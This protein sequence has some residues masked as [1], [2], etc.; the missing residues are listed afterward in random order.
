VPSPPMKGTQ[1]YDLPQGVPEPTGNGQ[2]SCGARFSTSQSRTRRPSD[3]GVRSRGPR[4]QPGRIPK[5]LSEAR[6]SGTPPDARRSKRAD[7][8]DSSDRRRRVVDADQ[9]CCR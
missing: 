4:V 1:Y 5:S 7:P 8:R 9:R 2:C 6:V 3:G